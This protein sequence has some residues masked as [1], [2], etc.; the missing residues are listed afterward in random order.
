[1]S[2]VTKINV[3]DAN[4][5]RYNSQRNVIKQTGETTLNYGEIKIMT[6]QD[7]DGFDIACL[8]I[9]FFSKW[10]DLFLQKRIKRL[11]TP[12]FVARKKKQDTKYFYSAEAYED[13]KSKLGGWEVEYMKGLGSLIE[14]DY[15][16]AIN[17]P[18]D[19][20]IIFDGDSRDSLDMAFGDNSQLR[21]EWL[22]SNRS[23]MTS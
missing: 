4:L 16:F 20:T 19:T 22:L 21:K 15:R 5:K 17:T 9:Q 18:N 23:H 3:N 13:V 8:L 14:E 11:N 1:M 12:L 6:D 2:T 10:P 7:P